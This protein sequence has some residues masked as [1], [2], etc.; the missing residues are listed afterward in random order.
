VVGF[1]LPEDEHIVMN[2]EH[3]ARNVVAM[4]MTPDGCWKTRCQLRENGQMW[5]TDLNDA[6]MVE[7]L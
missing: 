5:G 7:K 6:K 1:S 3:H 2:R 4:V